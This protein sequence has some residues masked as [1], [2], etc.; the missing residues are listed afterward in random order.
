[1]S[2]N[3][4]TW[5]PP[6]KRAKLGYMLDTF[7]Q[8]KHTLYTAT[9]ENTISCNQYSILQ[10][11]YSILYLCHG[12][13][14]SNFIGSLVKSPCQYFT[15]SSLVA[16]YTRSCWEPIVYAPWT[17]GEQL[18]V[19]MAQCALIYIHQ[20]VIG[21]QNQCKTVYT[22]DDWVKPLDPHKFSNPVQHI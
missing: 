19:Y 15:C 6:N 4:S 21:W 16:C 11:Y 7:F 13:Y 2:L 1:M 8:V 3:C 22:S 5:P 9:F 17:H 18:S 20:H 10:W 12:M 14:Y